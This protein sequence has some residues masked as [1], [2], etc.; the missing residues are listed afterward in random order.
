M[1][2]KKILENSMNN[3]EKDINK[4]NLETVDL[5]KGLKNKEIALSSAKED[6]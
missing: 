4:K 5:Q 1:A 2:D 6:A 3:L